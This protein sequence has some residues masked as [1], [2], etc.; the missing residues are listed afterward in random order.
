MA[1]LFDSPQISHILVESLADQLN[2]LDAGKSV[3]ALACVNTTLSQTLSDVFSFWRFYAVFEW[4]WPNGLIRKCIV[5]FN[6]LWRAEEL[7]AMTE[8]CLE[9]HFGPVSVFRDTDPRSFNKF[10]LY[11]VNQWFLDFN[12]VPPILHFSMGCTERE[13]IFTTTH[14]NH[15]WT[16]EFDVYVT[17]S[18][19]EEQTGEFTIL[20][21]QMRIRMNSVPLM[22]RQ[23]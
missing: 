20:L 7:A 21:H 10:S 12:D 8:L 3:R 2:S 13:L 6:R 14:T 23:S 15:L 5:K 1:S 4:T 17:Q 19:R 16:D 18:L 11:A 9:E 22:F